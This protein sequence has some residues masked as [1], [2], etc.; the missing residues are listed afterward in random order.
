[1]NVNMNMIEYDYRN[2]AYEYLIS[3]DIQVGI[4]TDN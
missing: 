3:G 4:W 1:M 2:V